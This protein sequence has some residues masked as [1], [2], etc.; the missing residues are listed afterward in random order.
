MLEDV[1]ATS[2]RKINIVINGMKEQPAEGF[3]SYQKRETEAAR[4]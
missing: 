2:G 4:A 1:Q 3:V